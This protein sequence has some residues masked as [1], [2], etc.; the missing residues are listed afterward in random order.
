[1][2]YFT[3]DIVLFPSMLTYDENLSTNKTTDRHRKFN[4]NHGG[5]LHTISIK[6]L[7]G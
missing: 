7:L 5:K 2:E 4:F 3:I 6:E 1:M